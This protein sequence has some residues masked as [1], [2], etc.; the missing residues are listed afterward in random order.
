M[1]VVTKIKQLMTTQV[2]V[3]LAC[4]LIIGIVTQLSWGFSLVSD[5][6]QFKRLNGDRARGVI[7]DFI[8][9]IISVMIA[10]SW[11]RIDKFIT[12]SQFSIILFMF[13]ELTNFLCDNALRNVHLRF[14]FETEISTVSTVW[15]FDNQNQIW[16]LNTLGND[17]KN[18]LK[19]CSARNQILEVGTPIVGFDKYVLDAQV[20]MN[21]Q[22]TFNTDE[23]T[24]YFQQNNCAYIKR[25]AGGVGTI[26]ENARS[27]GCMRRVRV[28]IQ[29]Q[30]YEEHEFICP[31]HLL[32]FEDKDLEMLTE[33]NPRYQV[34]STNVGVSTRK[35][36]IEP[37][38]TSELPIPCL[39][40]T[41]RQPAY[42]N[43]S[44]VS[45]MV[46]T[47]VQ[48]IGKV[49]LKYMLSGTPN[50]RLI[51]NNDLSN[52]LDDKYASGDFNPEWRLSN[53]NTP[54]RHAITLS[55][56]ELNSA[57]LS[58]T[59]L[60]FNDYVEVNGEYWQPYHD[61]V[62]YINTQN[63]LCFYV[64]TKSVGNSSLN[65]F[66]YFLD[67]L[68]IIRSVSISL[69]T[70]FLLS[71]VEQAINSVVCKNK[72]QF[73]K[74]RYMWLIGLLVANVLGS[75]PINMIRFGWAYS[76]DR[77]SG[78]TLE[79]NFV[80]LLFLLLSAFYLR[81]NQN[82][83]FPLHMKVTL[84]VGG[85][86]L[87]VMYDTISNILLNERDCPATINGT[88][89]DDNNT[90]TEYIRRQKNTAKI[91]TYVCICVMITIYVTPIYV[92][93]KLMHKKSQDCVLC[94]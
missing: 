70:L 62:E 16:E 2:L 54:P 48:P 66:K 37:M 8:V 30:F 56:E 88:N 75:T 65:T 44:A 33:N 80:I 13:Q 71:T 93:F 20:G 92:Q 73:G 74:D 19:Y 29:N 34:V 58:N 22:M 26:T 24:D 32:L 18:Q 5:F 51:E 59:L 57:N 86:F 15:L 27:D 90:D 39:S 72:T 89:L 6:G 68:M 31:V 40:S 60:N 94:L 55:Y 14:H 84:V 41:D 63:R 61:D 35:M 67:P 78:N 43:F 79:T 12:V 77:R 23:I 25:F 36:Y 1:T 7:T 45:V 3:V 4:V 83:P 9:G 76:E 81:V 49:W 38:S 46:Q 53:S 21:I 85:L 28:K 64:P 10:A 42:P 47:N 17:E 69:I 11:L 87:L 50:G 82:D 52:I 91:V